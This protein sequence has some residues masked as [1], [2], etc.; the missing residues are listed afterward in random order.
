MSSSVNSFVPHGRP[1]AGNYT[2]GLDLGSNSIGWGIVT[3]DGTPIDAGVRIFE[4]GTLKEKGDESPEK[5]R[6]EQRRLARQAR[7]QGARR[8]SRWHQTAVILKQVGLLP[9][10]NVPN[11]IG[12]PYELRRDAL[13]RPLTLHEIGRA[14]HHLGKRRGF[15]SGLKS[16]PKEGD[17]K[18]EGIVKAGISELHRKMAEKGVRT[19]G[20]YLAL[21][22]PHQERRRKHY[23]DREG[24]IAEF[25][26]IWAAQ[27][28]HHPTVLTEELRERLYHRIFFQRPL[29]PNDKLI[30]HCRL[31]KGKKRCPRASW[32]AESVRVRQEVNNLQIL[33]ANGESRPLTKAEKDKVYHKL[34][35][36]KTEVA[37]TALA[38][39]LKLAD[40]DQFNLEAGARKKLKSH[41]VEAGLRDHFGKRFDS[42]ATQLTQEIWEKFIDAEDDD[43]IRRCKE[44]NWP[45]TEEDL[46]A[47]GRIY[48][49][50]PDG[51][52][53]YSREA[54][55]KLLPPLEEGMRLYDALQ[56]IPEYTEVEDATSVSK[57]PPV[58]TERINNPV[59]KRTLSETRKLVNAIIR[60]YGKPARILIELARETRGTMQQR[61]DRIRENRR[62]E[63][64]RED[65]ARALADAKPSIPINRDTI[66]KYLLW[67]ECGHM[68]V[69]TGKAISFEDL[70]ASPSRFDIEHIIPYSRSM[71]NSMRN[72][73]L[74]DSRF[75]RE[76]KRN[77]TP[78]ET[79]GIGTPEFE[80]F[81]L[82]VQS[83][84]NME[85][86]KKK[87]FRLAE[88]PDDFKN[89]QLTDT[90]YSAREAR[91]FLRQLGIPV[92]T[93]RGTITNDLRHFWKMTELL[94][95]R[96]GAEA[97]GDSEGEA[98]APTGLRKKKKVRLDHRHHAIDALVIAA[99]TRSAINQLSRRFELRAAGAHLELPPPCPDFVSRVRALIDR[100]VVSHRPEH[101]LMAGFSKDTNYGRIQRPGTP[102]PVFVTRR[103]LD[104]M[105]VWKPKF[106]ETICDPADAESIRRHLRE[107][108]LD[109]AVEHKKLPPDFFNDLRKIARPGRVAPPIRKVRVWENASSYIPVPADAPT[110]YIAPEN[111]HH[112]ALYRVPDRKGGY[113]YAALVCSRLEALRRHR[114]KQP[115][116]LPEHPDHP[117]HSQLV[118]WFMKGDPLAYRGDDGQE[119][120]YRVQKIS[121]P[122]ATDGLDLVLRL[123]SEATLDIDTE[124][125]RVRICSLGR[126]KMEIDGQLRLRKVSVSLLGE[127]EG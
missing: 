94:P 6:G 83:C 91:A 41:A 98:E 117:G 50:C 124:P 110:R 12:D 111:N 85:W 99:T 115:I 100:M 90:S 80:Q 15:K 28:P 73:T 9:E 7:R 23:L 78:A 72:V 30:G 56:S 39:L 17:E 27:Q 112:L 69:Y 49:R 58:D 75:N 45:I 114:A 55:Q 95:R 84:R 122:P 121:G 87:L 26:A 67:Q 60:K 88:I 18:E 10:E 48:R 47:M 46:E 36:T 37:F 35:T 33:C 21:L 77:R 113:T 24:V 109:P 64:L 43:F 14:L 82:R 125:Q 8:R 96:D 107:R 70:F 93:T 66:R 31:E 71:D 51:Y 103:R 13:V 126:G 76:H 25:N 32:W 116:V 53:A 63:K 68:C 16:G 105:L 118:L 101:K 11:A 120:I 4:A 38:R 61:N 1:F 3:E 40:G 81:L 59:V 123:H 106:L 97:E 22:D 119:R 42:I 5:S 92:E 34:C 19:I 44:S 86:H 57:L 54:L 127:V 79:F 52:A 89:S 104:G 74:C 20:A 62:L 2:L 108:G 29:K 102:G 65:A